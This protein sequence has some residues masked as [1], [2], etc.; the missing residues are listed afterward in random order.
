MLKHVIYC[1]LP[2]FIYANGAPELAVGLCMGAAGVTGI[3]GTFMFTRLR[4]RIGLERT[5]LFAFTFEITLLSLCVLSIFAPGS[6]FVYNFKPGEHT[7]NN[8]CISY[9]ETASRPAIPVEV[10]G[11]NSTDYVHNI[12][13][14]D[15][16][17]WDLHTED[18]EFDQHLWVIPAASNWKVDIIEGFAD[19]GIGNADTQ[20]IP[21]F[22]SLDL[23]IFAESNNPKQSSIIRNNLTVNHFVFYS[24]KDY[25][26]IHNGAS[27]G[28]VEQV[29]KLVKREVTRESHD[30]QE[31]SNKTD[32]ESKKEHTAVDYISVTLFLIGIVASRIGKYF[33]IKLYIL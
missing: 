26:L 33:Y 30:T 7:E 3:I 24:S 25:H 6:L 14:R 9:G 23:N 20:N 19:M 17:K 2:G 13:K 11:I 15:L 22:Y 12:T 4:P 28:E 5:G 29:H 1:F 18:I 16:M 21:G 27:V 8:T 31:S 10:N 32:C